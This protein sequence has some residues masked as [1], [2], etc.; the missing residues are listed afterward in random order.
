[1]GAA[2]ARATARVRAHT[3]HTRTARVVARLDVVQQRQVGKVVHVHLLRQ[4]DDD[5]VAPQPHGAHVG[6][7]GELADAPVLVVVPDHH[8]VRR[9]ARGL[10]GAAAAAAVGGRA[11]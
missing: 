1:M 9:K 8:L 7:E 4:R 2:A 3:P 10:R 5:A 6:A 11:Q